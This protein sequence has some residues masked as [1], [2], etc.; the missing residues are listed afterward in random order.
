MG[1]AGTLSRPGRV[2]QQGFSNVSLP[3]FDPEYLKHTM[4]NG[5]CYITPGMAMNW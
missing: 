2:V 5:T 4:D 3:V 1:T